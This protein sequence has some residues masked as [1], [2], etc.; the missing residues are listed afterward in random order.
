MTTATTIPA[1]TLDN[2]HTLSDE[3]LL[4]EYRDAKAAGDKHRMNRFFSAITERVKRKVQ[5]RAN[6]VILDAS[7]RDI[8]VWTAIGK[9]AM[10]DEAFDNVLT[11]VRNGENLANCVAAF[12][13][14]DSMKA[15][16]NQGRSISATGKGGGS[17]SV[18][19]TDFTADETMVTVSGTSY[20]MD[21]L[22]EALDA[23]L[24]G[25][26][27][28]ADE[29]CDWFRE[30]TN[31]HLTTDEQDALLHSTGLTREVDGYLDDLAITDPA[32]AA[33]AFNAVNPNPKNAARRIGPARLPQEH[34][35]N[36]VGHDQQ[37]VSGT[38]DSAENAI[39]ANTG[40]TRDLRRGI[41]GTRRVIFEDIT[42]HLIGWLK[43]YAD[44]AGV[45]ADETTVRAIPQVYWV[46]VMDEFGYDIDDYSDADLADI[47]EAVIAGVTK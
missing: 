38:I 28:A 27:T 35:G 40:L 37:W 30:S 3:T 4:V 2:T 47:V 34:V 22:D 32:R 39:Y 15:E 45:T 13:T 1:V 7:D 46:T 8:A 19:P 29:A 26:P 42:A 25:A 11:A 41:D 9:L 5:A 6:K 36:I 20:T 10:D 24:Y 12:I 33:R 14:S 17:M 31:G 43:T 21:A 18:T 16:L 44:Q 23:A